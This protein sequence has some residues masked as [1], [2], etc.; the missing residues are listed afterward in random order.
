[1]C[2]YLDLP[3]YSIQYLKGELFTE[4]DWLMEHG[5]PHSEQSVVIIQVRHQQ[6]QLQGG[7]KEK[8]Q[9]M[10]DE[11]WMV[12]T[13]PVTTPLSLNVC[14]A[15]DTVRPWISLVQW[16]WQLAKVPF[17]KISQHATLSKLP[18]LHGFEGSYLHPQRVEVPVYKWVVTHKYIH[19]AHPL[20][21]IHP[22]WKMQKSEIYTWGITN[23]WMY[24]EE[25]RHSWILMTDLPVSILDLATNSL[26]WDA[27]I[28]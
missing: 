8:D 16:Q 26:F 1:M 22:V 9:W 2:I 3:L 25:W 5:L 6:L 20:A 21:S 23:S 7:L 24:Y 28:N 19:K 18:C 14:M 10:V 15:S 27:S 12:P 4:H 13:W 17:S 11:G